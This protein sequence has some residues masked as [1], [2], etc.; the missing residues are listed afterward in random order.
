MIIKISNKPYE[1]A[2]KEEVKEGL[3]EELNTTK[4]ELKE[5]IREYIKELNANP[6][7]E[8][9]S[10]TKKELT[11]EISATKEELTNKI[12]TTNQELTNK[13]N[14]TNQELTNKINTTKEATMQEMFEI[15][16]PVGSVYVSFNNDFDPRMMWNESNWE[17][18]KE[19]IFLDSVPPSEETMG[20]QG[21]CAWRRIG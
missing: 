2:T 7:Q 19:G 9:I 10:A 11:E 18:V 4:E 20:Q 16:Y 8:E 3:T 12:N 1:L 13:I 15:L 14:T 6:N 5:E 21:A 17:K